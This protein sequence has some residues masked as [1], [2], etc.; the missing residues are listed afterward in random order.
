MAKLVPGAPP[1]NKATIIPRGQAL[2]M[3]SWLEEE[4][5]TR[6]LTECRARLITGL[7]GRCSELLVFGE[8]TSGATS[9]YKQV[10]ALARA[11]VCDWGMSDNLGPLSLGSGDDEVFL[12]KGFTQTRSFSEHTAQ[13]IDE[14]IKKFVLEAEQSASDLL[15]K[16]H[17]KLTAVAEGLLLYEV[18]DSADMDKVIAGEP[19]IREG[20]EDDDVGDG[21]DSSPDLSPGSSPGDA[22]AADTQSGRPEPE[23]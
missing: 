15:K 10:T 20:D 14:E 7:A 23:L 8:L 18:L 6:T 13:M 4:T 16:N 11:M 17:D 3:V 21:P 2:G 19:V 12:G 5:H 9:D 1:I 22:T